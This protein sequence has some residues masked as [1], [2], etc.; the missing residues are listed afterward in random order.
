[1]QIGLGGDVHWEWPDQCAACNLDFIQRGMQELCLNTS[2]LGV[3]HPFSGNLV[4]QR[5]RIAYFRKA[6]GQNHTSCQR[7]VTNTM[8]LRTVTT[9]FGI[10]FPD[11]LARRVCWH[12]KRWYSE[13]TRNNRAS[14]EETEESHWNTSDGSRSN[15]ERVGTIDTTLAE[16]IQQ[17]WDSVKTRL[18]SQRYVVKEPHLL[19][20]DLHAIL[21]VHH[22]RK[23]KNNVRTQSQVWKPF[24]PSGKAFRLIKQNG[25]TPQTTLITSFQ[26]SLMK[27]VIWR[28]P[29]CFFFM[30]DAGLHRNPIWI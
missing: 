27:V 22:V 30:S 6:T 26:L 19:F 18:W 9:L 4:E 29:K 10:P 21:S 23:S 2:A 13:G 24:L 14:H 11:A 20:S 17:L 8:R 15:Q 1:M 5:W 3:K 25:V 28:W 16:H 7:R 12:R